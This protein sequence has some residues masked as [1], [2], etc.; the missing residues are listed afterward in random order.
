MFSNQFNIS[1][2]EV[3]A[4]HLKDNNSLIGFG[5]PRIADTNQSD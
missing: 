1:I 2:T 4:I 3:L 5:Y